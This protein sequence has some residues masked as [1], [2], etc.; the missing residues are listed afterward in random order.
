M[1]QVIFSGIVLGLTVGVGCAFL[2]GLTMNM[3]LGN[4][5]VRKGIVASLAMSLGRLTLYATLG[6]LLGIVGNALSPA[7]VRVA[8]YPIATM[9][10]G[11][12]LLSHGL[13]SAL[14]SN[15]FTRPFKRLMAPTLCRYL[16]RQ[17]DPEAHP[18]SARPPVSEKSNPYLPGLLPRMLSFLQEFRGIPW[19]S[20]VLAGILGCT[21]SVPLL[22]AIAFS[23][24]LGGILESVVF[25]LSFGVGSSIYMLT[26]GAV[27]G[28]F[29]GVGLR[30]GKIDR[31]RRIT[32][33][34]CIVV[35]LA[36]VN[37][38]L[39]HIPFVLG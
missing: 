26:L 36:F 32:G 14:G 6:L 37:N 4:T 23:V 35:G 5:S 9:A 7:E 3:A 28:A 8:L 16:P 11:F 27:S 30:H 13:S 21:E 18:P 24:T 25:M 1:F 31:V 22:L 17:K 38:G 2:C 20:S 33:W 15:R 39:M 12:W 34:A 29:F 19:R 10:L